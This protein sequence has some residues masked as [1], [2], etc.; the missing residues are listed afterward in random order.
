MLPP[1]LLPLLLLLLEAADDAMA[2]VRAWVGVYVLSAASPP[3]HSRSHSHPH[4]QVRGKTTNKP[5]C[6]G[7]CLWCVE[8]PHTVQSVGMLFKSH[9]MH[10]SKEQIAD[11]HTIVCKVSR[12]H[13][14]LLGHASITTCVGV[15]DEPCQA[16][17]R[18]LMRLTA[19]VVLAHIR[20]E[21]VCGAAPPR[22]I[23][24]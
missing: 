7:A 2:S 9:T 14:V 8:C 11:T 13:L 18:H 3:L 20:H 1:L 5:L 22:G 6:S 17:E 16:R 15:S 4:H 21:V 10:M 12:F 24:V 19:V 23:I